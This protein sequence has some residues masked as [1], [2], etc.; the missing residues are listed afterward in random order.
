MQEED[1]DRACRFL[2][3]LVAA[4]QRYGVSSSAMESLLA[5]VARA[6][7]VQGQFLATPNQV[8]SILWDTDE[9]RQRLHI[10]V[11]SGGNYDMTKLSQISELLGKL[12]SG[13]MTPDA[14]LE[15]LRAIHRAGPEY[16]PAMDGVAFALCGF[17][18]GVILGLSW[19]DVL[20]AGALGV[21]PFGLVRV[22]AGSRGLTTAIEL[23]AAAVASALATLLALVFPGTSALAVAVCACIYFVPGFALTLGAS[24]LMGG[25]TLSGLIGFTRAAVTGVKL[26]V[27]ALIGSAI[28]S[29][30]ATIPP[31]ELGSGV[32]HAWTWVFSPVLV[33]GLA[34]LFR[35]RRR[36]LFW[37]LLGGLIV[38]L[39]VEAGSGLGFWQGTFI[40]A[41]LLMGASRLFTRVTRLPSAIILLPAVMLLVPGVAA[42]E[43]LYMGQTLGLA[44]GLQS[45][46][47]VMV[48][49]AA[50]LGGL[51][52]SEAVWSIREVA[53]STIASRR[54]RGA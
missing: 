2:N 17:G 41:F 1:F 13:E 35:V 11:S 28:V 23:V 51:L 32:P 31:R 8:Q 36:D 40:G 44:E 29:S 39:A 12:E 19:M 21:V 14:G 15:R 50:I 4:V 45:A 48:L 3:A 37:P 46:S 5:R 49:I 20:L 9:D 33:L 10:S 7:H 27:G 43:A 53:I 30:W 34:I 47:E 24:E 6:L 18:F 25:N 22:S 38:W 54:S 52:L 26:V 42:L 16:G